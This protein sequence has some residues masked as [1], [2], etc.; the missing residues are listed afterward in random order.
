MDVTPIP[1]DM[2]VLFTL[3]AAHTQ[4]ETASEITKRP[5]WDYLMEVKGNQPTLH[6]AVFDIVLP[7]L[8]ARPHH[9]MEGRSRGPGAFVA[10]ETEGR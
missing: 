5:G 10:L 1:D 3:D 9:V 8:R 4:W 6:R 2:R 7:H